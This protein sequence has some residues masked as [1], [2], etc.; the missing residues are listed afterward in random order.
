MISQ[1]WM[2]ACGEVAADCTLLSPKA[3]SSLSESPVQHSNLQ[4]H[5]CGTACCLSSAGTSH[6][7]SSS[8]PH[9]VQSCSNLP[10]QDLMPARC[11]PPRLYI[12]NMSPSL[13]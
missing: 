10:P 5:S 11:L 9:D 7:Y 8:H 1:G 3:I 4:E 12:L 13:L 2:V 6:L